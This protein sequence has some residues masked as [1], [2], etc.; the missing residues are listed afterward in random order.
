MTGASFIPHDVAA[1]VARAEAVA[2]LLDRF[3]SAFASVDD[4]NDTGDLEPG[5]LDR[6]GSAQGG[7]SSGDGVLDDREPSASGEMVGAFEHLLGAMALCRLA[8][9]DGVDALAIGPRSEGHRR[10]QRTSAELHARH[11]RNRPERVADP[12]EERLPDQ[13]VP[14]GEENSRLAVD[15]E[16]ALLP[17]AQDE[18][19]APKTSYAQQLE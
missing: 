8:N 18:V 19:A 9:V 4:R 2:C 3:G 10:S 6:I 17:G 12:F 5:V 15:E 7:A 13:H 11:T 1:L 14:F 16:V